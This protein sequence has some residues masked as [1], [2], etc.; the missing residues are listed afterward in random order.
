MEKFGLVKLLVVLL[1]LA[2]LAKYTGWLGPNTYDDCIIEGMQGVGDAR[3]ANAVERACL[4]KFPEE[5]DKQ[6]RAA[7]EQK[8]RA[9]AEQKRREA[10]RIRYEAE[11]K[12]EVEIQEQKFNACMQEFVA[13]NQYSKRKLAVN[14]RAMTIEDVD[15]SFKGD[16]NNFHILDLG[17]DIGTRIP[18]PKADLE[19]RAKKECEKKLGV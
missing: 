6:E 7:T 8:R 5:T 10:E 16:I 1:F 19:N 12:M 3:A 11:R 4:S 14:E 15:S 18:S 9:V 13:N 17:N 2:A